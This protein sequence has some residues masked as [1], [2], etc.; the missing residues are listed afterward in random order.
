MKKYFCPKC[1]TENIEINPTAL[2]SATGLNPNLRCLDCN[3]SALAFP[4][5]Q[6]T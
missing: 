2:E 6:K 4:T 5:K 1:K 3:F